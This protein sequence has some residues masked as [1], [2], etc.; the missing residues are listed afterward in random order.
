MMIACLQKKII[1]IF[2]FFSFVWKRPW[3]WGS[4]LSVGYIVCYL[5]FLSKYS[6]FCFQTTFLGIEIP[7]DKIA[8]WFD[9]HI[10]CLQANDLGDAFAGLFAP[11]SFFWLA[12]SIII[13]SRESRTK[14]E[15]KDFL[16]I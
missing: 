3:L 6:K 13:Q 7:L 4:I 16:E 15:N 11:L 2:S 14:R 8:N 12:G 10:S 5:Y 1:S 9:R